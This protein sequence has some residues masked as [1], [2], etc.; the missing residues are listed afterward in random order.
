VC[1]RYGAQN[2][3]LFG[4]VARGDATATSDLD[5]LV[6]L[7]PRRGNPLMRVAG[8]AEELTDLLDVRGWTSSRRPCCAMRSASVRADLVATVSRDLHA[9]FGYFRV[10]HDLIAAIVHDEL[11]PARRRNRPTPESVSLPVKAWQHTGHYF[12][13]VQVRTRV[14]SG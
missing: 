3:R 14:A 1:D 13:I 5:L 12:V 6:D 8:I 11:A 4:S 10:N 2:P 7:G 9:P